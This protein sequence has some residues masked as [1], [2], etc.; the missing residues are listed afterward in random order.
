MDIYRQQ[1]ID[2][3]QQC[4]KRRS[5]L[6]LAARSGNSEAVRLLLQAGA[7]PSLEDKRGRTLLHGAAEFEFRT[8]AQR[9][10]LAK[11]AVGPPELERGK[12]TTGVRKDA[13]SR[14]GLVVSD[15]DDAKCIQ[16][17]IQ[18]LLSAGANPGHMDVNRHRPVDV[19]VMLGC[20]PAIDEL[21]HFSKNLNLQSLD[22][23]GK[24]LSTITELRVR[25]I[26]DSTEVP[27]DT[28]FLER[29][30]STGNGRL[31]E[32]FV[33]KQPLKLV[34][35]TNK[36]PLYLLARWVFTSMMKKLLPYVE[37]LGAW[38]SSLLE[39]A[40]K[41]SLSNLGMIKFLLKH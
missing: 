28:R 34:E 11:I 16:E 40:A 13:F 25:E 29:V 19:A 3:D 8:H 23:V 20:S 4:A 31:A 7:N 24:S 21:R 27:E 1:A 32:A 17:V 26:V 14:M 41:R 18:L 15:E 38:I 30:F 9:V 39:H 33:Q 10:Q 36:S 35:D 12:V 37:D 2:V 6:H 22:S 5:A